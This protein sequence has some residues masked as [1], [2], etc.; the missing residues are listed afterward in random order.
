MSGNTAFDPHVI[1]LFLLVQ[2]RNIA[3]CI[4][5]K[6]SDDDRAVPLKVRRQDL[7]NSCNR[8]MSELN[9]CTT[10]DHL[11][12]QSGELLCVN[13]PWLKPEVHPVL[14]ERVVCAAISP[15]PYVL[16]HMHVQ[17]YVLLW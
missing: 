15:H 9:H 16:P 14:G 17:C 11:L 12:M 6:D 3:C 1:P 8:K 13:I 2:A 10:V 7:R 5:L 4:E